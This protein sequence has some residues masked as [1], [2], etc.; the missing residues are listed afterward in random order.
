MNCP[1][2][3]GDN[4]LSV[5]FCQTCGTNLNMDADQ[6]AVS[7]REK[8]QGDAVKNTAHTMRNLFMFGVSMLFLS[9]TLFVMSGGVPE[10]SYHQIPSAANGAKYVEIEYDLDVSFPALQIPLGETPK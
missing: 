9:L 8:A 7:F 3:G 4:P 5:T 10:E 2:C 1:G 6:I